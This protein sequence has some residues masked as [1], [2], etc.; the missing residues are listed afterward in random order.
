MRRVSCPPPR[1]LDVPWKLLRARPARRRVP[2]AARR[3][4]LSRVA[5][6]RPRRRL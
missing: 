4:P 5:P 3:G 2:R 1:R 6:F